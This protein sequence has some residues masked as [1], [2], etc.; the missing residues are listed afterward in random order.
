MSDSDESP[1]LFCESVALHE[2][3]HN[4]GRPHEHQ[5]AN[6]LDYMIIDYNNIDT[7]WLGNF[8]LTEAIFLTPVELSSNMAYSGYDAALDQSKPVITD[9]QGKTYEA[10]KTLTELDKKKYLE[11]YPF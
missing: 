10:S 11:L 3:G 2:L 4:L 9:L 8:K 6:A 1:P 5:L 7:D